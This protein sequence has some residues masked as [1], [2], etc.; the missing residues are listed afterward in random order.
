M[1]AMAMLV[2]E[3]GEH[4]KRWD[5]VKIN[6][7]YYFYE[8]HKEGDV[9]DEFTLNLSIW[10]LFSYPA[11]NL[12]KLWVENACFDE[13]MLPNEQFTSCL[14]LESLTDLRIIGSTTQ[15]YFFGVNFESVT[16]LRL[17]ADTGSPSQ[18]LV[19][20]RF[21]HLQ[22][23]VVWCNSMDTPS[24]SATIRLPSLQTLSIKFYSPTLTIWDTPILQILTLD[25]PSGILTS[26][27]LPNVQASHVCWI[28]EQNNSNSSYYYSS[29]STPR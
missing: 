18:M 23:L 19:L 1:E 4:M 17:E 5:T 14:Q 16:T 24:T 27:E 13:E 6:L 28:S 10:R 29:H 15:W 7:P 9:E 12:T 8:V 22:H 21:T 3:N 20:S 2:G 25:L 11:P 26:V